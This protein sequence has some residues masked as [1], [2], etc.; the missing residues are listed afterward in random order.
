MMDKSFLIF[1]LVGFGFLY[2]VTNFVGD[3]QEE[4]DQY[5]NLEYQQKHKYD[6]YH[7]VDSIG[8]EIL[9]LTGT[10]TA[11]QVAAWKESRLKQEFLSLFP[12][13]DGM[14]LFV[15]ERI[16]GNTLQSKLIRKIDNVENKYFSG[17]ITAE[18]AKR[19]LDLLK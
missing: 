9:D 10:N 14:K 2:V 13:F 18:Q 12:D 4:D 16:R 17:T 1:I 5:Q 8:E 6:Q 11:T 19:E 7:S 3:I 15:Q